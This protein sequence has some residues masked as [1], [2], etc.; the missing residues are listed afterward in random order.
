MLFLHIFGAVMAAVGLV[1][2]AMY[3]IKGAKGEESTMKVW[4]INLSGP[5]PLVL[6]VAGALIAIFPFTSFFQNPSDPNPPEAQPTTTL[7]E[8]A[9]TLNNPDTTTATTLIP[10]V[11]LPLSPDSFEVT[12]D[13]TCQE[14]AIFWNQ[15]E[16]ENVAGW[17]LSF[18][19]YD[20]DTGE[21]FS[22]FEL[23]TQVDTPTFGN[24]SGICELD[25]VTDVAL[26]YSIWV[27][28]YNAAGYSEPLYLE[29][30]DR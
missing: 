3:Q 13:E 14:D 12:F 11:G 5:A 10:E 26:D 1:L 28:A 19:S 9:T 25:F 7:S 23:D 6:I 30:A 18:E 24:W 8:S 17:W 22:T 4:Q 16:I 21:V 29:Y 27:Y 20:I 2:L 15:P